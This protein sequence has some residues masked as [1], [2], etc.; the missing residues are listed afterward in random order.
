ME[1]VSY[2]L[3]FDGAAEEAAEFYVSVFKDSRIVSVSRF[4]EGSPGTPGT[5]MTM[6]FVLNGHDF[7]DC[8]LGHRAQLRPIAGLQCEACGLGPLVHIRVREHGTDLH[9]G[10]FADETAEIVH[11]P[12]GLKQIMH[13]GNALADVD[14]AG[15]SCPGRISHDAVALDSP[16]SH[17]QRDQQDCCQRQS[18]P[19]L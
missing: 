15:R 5:V 11:A 14:F 13:R 10:A 2:C 9:G 6:Q 19:G 8:L 18:R 12:V 16:H 1:T 4:P 3:W 17:P 7:L